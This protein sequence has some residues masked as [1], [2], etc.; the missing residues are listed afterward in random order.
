MNQIFETLYLLKL[1]SIF[2][3]SLDNFDK[4]RYENK[5]KLIFDQWPKLYLGLNAQNSNVKWTLT[6]LSDFVIAEHNST[7]SSASPLNPEPVTSN[8]TIP[9]TEE[10]IKKEVVIIHDPKNPNQVEVCMDGQSTFVT[11]RPHSRKSVGAKSKDSN[12]KSRKSCKDKITNSPSDSEAYGT[13]S[14]VSEAID[15]ANCPH[16][17]DPSREDQPSRHSRLDSK[18]T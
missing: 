5:L 10:P 2:V 16:G 18:F 11:M 15:N 9:V 7:S 4:S 14:S 8:G 1:C 6:Y 12:K 17:E 13:G 3:L